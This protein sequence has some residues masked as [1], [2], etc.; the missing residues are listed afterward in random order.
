MRSL[1]NDGTEIDGLLLL[2]ILVSLVV[3]P[4]VLILLILVIISVAVVIVS[5][6][7]LLAVTPVY[8]L[9]LRFGRCRPAAYPAAICIASFETLV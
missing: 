8:L 9:I 3:T 6:C 2:L 4:L 7:C 5:A 1:G